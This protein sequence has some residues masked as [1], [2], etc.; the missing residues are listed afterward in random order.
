M[1]V[2]AGNGNLTL[3]KICVCLWQW[4]KLDM[5]LMVVGV[6]EAASTPGW[7]RG[8]RWNVMRGGGGNGRPGGPE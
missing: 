3:G 5:Y 8:S 7:R 1:I 4:Y 2:E 6:D